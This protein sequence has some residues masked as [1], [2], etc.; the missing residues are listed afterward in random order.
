MPT[1]PPM[2]RVLK[3]SVL[4]VLY[5]FVISVES[6]NASSMERF[7]RTLQ[8]VPFDRFESLLALVGL[9]L[10]LLLIL[11]IAAVRAGQA[12]RQEAA[13]AAE[14]QA[15]LAERLAA[16]AQSNAELTGRMRGMGE[17]LGA[18][19]SDLA[20]LVAERLDAV[21][22]RV[23]RGLEDQSRTANESLAKLNERLAVIDAAQ[24]R[25]TGLTEEV[26]G[27]KDILANKQARGAFGQGRMEAIIRDAL[28]A[29]AY[30][31]QPTLSN[32]NRPDCGIRLPGDDRLLVVDAKF[33]LESFAA[34]KD[35]ASEEAQK[36]AQTRVRADVGKHIRDISERYFLPGE[37]QDLAILFVP[38]ES[39][40]ADL[41]EHFEDVIQKAHKSRIII[42]SPSLLVMAV[43][44]MQ[45]I[46][47]DARVREQA[48]VI[49]IEVRRL[50]ED[51]VRLR[52]RVG[53]LGVHFRQAEED[54]AAI[55]TSAEKIGKRGERIDQ[56]DFARPEISPVEESDLS[57]A[58]L[59][60]ARRG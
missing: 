3:S 41:A 11:A 52:E 50:V 21:G 30:E 35:A 23:G 55:A 40:Y 57:G 17:Y 56:M 36:Q 26:I 31:F 49:Q 14:R 25:L 53:K 5:S 2:S 58:P 43:Q 22:A 16:L 18:R 27:L 38:S 20:R 12:R 34:L 32:R 42:V 45:A 6:A 51:V 37:T 1:R 24:A 46:V 8:A 13:T 4:N 29:S 19:H 39:L 7:F 48:H 59:A 15:E 47:R 44:V 9:A 10:S 54:V 33:P 28:P 60:D